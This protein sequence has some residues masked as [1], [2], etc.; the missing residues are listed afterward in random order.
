M[1]TPSAI[2]VRVPASTANL[3]P[4]FDAVGMAL[5]LHDEIEA[6]VLE[7]GFVVEV[8]DAGAGA[9]GAIP[10]DERHLV[11]RAARRMAERIGHPLPGLWL[12]CHNAIPHA[13]G[14]GSSAAAIVA[15]AAIT[16]AF[17]GSELD[18]AML[19]LAVDF[20]GHA[21]N[22][23]ASLLG[24]AVVTWHDGRWRASRVVPHPTVR[25]VVAIARETSST[26]A[27]RGLLPQQVPHADAVWS[28]GR[29][30]LLV[31]ALTAAP[32]HLLAGT[33][34]RLHQDYRAAAYPRSAEL[35]AQ[36]RKHGV[37]AA[38]SGAG[39]TVLALT[40]DG[41][42]PDVDVTGFDVAALGVDDAG[43][44]VVPQR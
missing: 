6:A 29:A 2:R 10:T 19:D 24:G 33:A 18:D 15:G 21:D 11:V 35:L 36:L 17:A 5:G 14:L 32:Q 16:A 23:A 12:R 43:V 9:V 27:T 42:L 30:A 4:G 28:A 37:P 26:A 31:H 1:S 22:A 44:T 40:A 39:P 41:A 3:G 8:V 25:P 34:D 38:I 7:D 13:R 20:E